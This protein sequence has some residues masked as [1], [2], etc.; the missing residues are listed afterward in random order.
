M[1]TETQNKQTAQQNPTE[2]VIQQLTEKNK[3]FSAYAKDV[4]TLL[5]DVVVNK[6]TEN[7]FKLL[8]Q[9]EETV[10]LLAET[11]KEKNIWLEKA[12]QIEADNKETI[13]EIKSAIKLQVSTGKAQIKTILERNNSI[14]KN[15]NQTLANLSELDIT[16]PNVATRVANITVWLQGEVTKTQKAISNAKKSKNELDRIERTISVKDY[17]KNTVNSYA[18]Q[19]AI[20]E[21]ELTTVDIYIGIEV[22]IINAVIPSIQDELKTVMDEAHGL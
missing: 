14:L 20:L 13:A 21:K 8:E 9:K 18:E 17:V 12:H 1:I 16:N 5:E 11:I 10:K 4:V 2:V 19:I 6:N 15:Q 22:Q 7:V 3:E